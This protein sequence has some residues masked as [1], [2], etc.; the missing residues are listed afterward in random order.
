MRSIPP[1]GR[2]LVTLCTYNERENL[3][4]LVA[5]ILDAAPHV[6]ILV[7]DD[8]SPDGTGILADQIASQQP[9]VHV[10]HRPHKQG[11]GR[12][13]L[14]ALREAL[15][16]EYDYW[17]NMDADFS[18]DPKVI[19]ALL[20]SLSHADV[21]MGSRYIPGGGTEGWSLVRRM[22]SRTINAY[23][24]LLLGLRTKDNSGAFRCY[25][26]SRLQT[27]DL[28]RFRATG[29]AVQEELLYRCR[30]AGCTFH[31][32]PITFRDRE[33]GQS[34]INLT[35]ALLAVWVLLQLAS[36]RLRG[37]PVVRVDK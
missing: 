35:E 21:V 26:L 10:L 8:N 15:T 16:Q 24:R 12:A 34:K 33:R 20:A 1:G 2:V 23:A 32:I 4:P 14:A 5:A 18:H 7:V 31:E 22:M 25:R 28:S 3:E 27:L 29:Y 19:P 17:L 11:L 36:D 6:D 37:V 13:T 30:R 9:Q